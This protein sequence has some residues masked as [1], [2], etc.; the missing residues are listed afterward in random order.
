MTPLC[1]VHAERLKD[2]IGLD[3]ARK[4]I[5]RRRM[6]WVKVGVMQ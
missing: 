1:L 3:S 6:K 5:V 2:A 4:Y